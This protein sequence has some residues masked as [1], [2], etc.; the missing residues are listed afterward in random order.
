MKG[1][2]RSKSLAVVIAFAMMTSAFVI[3]NNE[4]E[5]TVSAYPPTT[6]PGYDDFGNATADLEYDPAT[7]QTVT[8]NTTGLEADTHY[9]LYKPKYANNSKNRERNKM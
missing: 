7:Y 8:I 1:N 4:K 9:Y 6:T 5:A 2:Y 3:L